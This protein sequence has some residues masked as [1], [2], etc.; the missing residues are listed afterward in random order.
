MARLIV[1]DDKIH[2]AAL[3]KINQ[4]NRSFV[5]DIKLQVEQN[6]IVILGMK[7]NPHC[8]AAC[9]NAAKAGH[10]YKYLE[11]GSY[12]TQ[13]RKR[14]SLKMWTG[15]PTFPM[16]FVKGQFIGGSSQFKKL[17]ASGEL[18]RML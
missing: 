7:W 16:I 1:S 13:W 10:D 3:E 18:D 2:L 4:L 14:N 6:E 11:H 9:K 12:L 15:W 8:P 5:E 17:I